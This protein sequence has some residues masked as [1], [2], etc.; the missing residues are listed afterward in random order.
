[1]PIKDDE[2]SA[3]ARRHALQAI[4]DVLRRS[5]S[6]FDTQPVSLIDEKESRELLQ[7]WRAI[8]HPVDRRLLTEMARALATKK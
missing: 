8:N 7:L 4:A 6:D 5:M 2:K 1:M 3:A